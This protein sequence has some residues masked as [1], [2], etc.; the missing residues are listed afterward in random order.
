MGFIGIDQQ[1][2]HRDDLLFK[3]FQKVGKVSQ[4]ANAVL[5][6]KVQKHQ[7]RRLTSGKIV[8]ASSLPRHFDA[9]E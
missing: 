9:R 7:E 1:E 8:G 5:P 2:K 4:A 6:F 3:V